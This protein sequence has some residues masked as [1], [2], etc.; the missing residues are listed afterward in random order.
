[1][2]VID[3]CRKLA[4]LPPDTEVYFFADDQDILQEIEIRSFQDD[5]NDGIFEQEDV[6]QFIADG[7][8]D[9]AD[10]V[11]IQAIG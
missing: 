8:I 6:L 4:K 11:Y 7:V 10:T 2:K 9:S 3:I 1:M 5:I